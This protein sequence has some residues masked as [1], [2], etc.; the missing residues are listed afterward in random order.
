MYV[1]ICVYTH[2]HTHTH[3]QALQ[4]EKDV[5]L[6]NGRTEWVKQHTTKTRDWEEKRSDGLEKQLDAEFSKAEHEVRVQGRLNTH[7]MYVCVC[8]CIYIYILCVVCVCV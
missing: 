3:T 4:A 8:V 6:V 2:T 7:N 5:Q 1:I